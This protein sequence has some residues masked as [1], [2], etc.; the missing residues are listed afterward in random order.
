MNTKLI[1]AQ[2]EDAEHNLARLKSYRQLMLATEVQDVPDYSDPAGW[3]RENA[4][5]RA[6]KLNAD[7]LLRVW[8]ALLKERI[9]LMGVP[10]RHGE[11]GEI[12][13]IINA[14]FMKLTAP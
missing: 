8:D 3:T 1:D 2:I 13:D 14:R 9:N 4:A 11:I 12:I 5:E 7:Q 10:A 6:A